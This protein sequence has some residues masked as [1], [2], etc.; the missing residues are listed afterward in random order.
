MPPWLVIASSAPLLRN[1]LRERARKLI[2]MSG[3]VARRVAN[4][5]YRT[6][7]DRRVDEIMASRVPLAPPGIFQQAE[8]PGNAASC[9]S[10]RRK[11]SYQARGRHRAGSCEFDE[12]QQNSIDG[13]PIMPI[14]LVDI[15]GNETNF[16]HFLMK[17]R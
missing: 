13:V 8:V 15:D 10:K 1:P 3:W 11:Q 6:A 9:S 2:P 14:E 7:I 5:V 17:A 12:R 4:G 16:G